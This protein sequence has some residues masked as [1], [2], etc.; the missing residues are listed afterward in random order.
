MYDTKVLSLYCG[1][2]IKS[3][4]GNLFQKCSTDKKFNN[5]LCFELDSQDRIDNYDMFKI[6]EE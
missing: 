1:K 5:N 6:Y 3:D 4:L 2:L